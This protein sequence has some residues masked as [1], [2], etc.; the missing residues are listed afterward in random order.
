MELITGIIVVVF[1][2][3]VLILY[4]LCWKDNLKWRWLQITITVIFAAILSP[5]IFHI[6]VSINN[7]AHEDAERQFRKAVIEGLYNQTVENR[8]LEQLLKL[9]YKDAFSSTEK[10]A[11]QWASDFLSTLPQKRENKKNLRNQSNKLVAKLELRWS[12]LYQFIIKSFD[13]RVQ[14]LTKA[15]LGAL[16]ESKDIH[17]VTNNQVNQTQTILR[18]FKFSNG[19]SLSL[20]VYTAVVDNGKV[21]WYPNI[22]F[23]EYLKDNNSTTVFSVNFRQNYF[24]LEAGHPRHKGYIK[25]LRTHDDPLKDSK[26]VE[27]LNTAINHAFESSLL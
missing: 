26:F 6:I 14:E 10:E 5:T 13:T 25:Q 17:L 23:S 27:M 20:R 4:E 24:E 2:V 22:I 8:D 19:N 9:K 11:K 18:K 16:V 3:G 1:L 12:P 7:R 15:S 21:T